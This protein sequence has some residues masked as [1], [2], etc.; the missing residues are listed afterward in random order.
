VL[1]HF[2][3]SLVFGMHLLALDG[4]LLKVAV[5]SWKSLPCDAPMGSC[6][7]IIS[8]VDQYSLAFCCGPKYF[9]RSLVIPQ[10]G[11]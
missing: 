11:P 8:F 1:K 9:L 6:S 3:G 5:S 7:D 4:I 2:F 10:S